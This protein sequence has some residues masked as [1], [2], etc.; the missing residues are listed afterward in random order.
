M[1]FDYW[2]VQGY[3]DADRLFRWAMPNTAAEVLGYF[4][5]KNQAHVTYV[6][7]FAIRAAQG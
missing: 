7:G 6:R 3:K 4:V 1:T 2:M 5:V